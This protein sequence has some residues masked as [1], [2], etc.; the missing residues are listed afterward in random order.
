MPVIKSAIKKLRKDLKRTKTND[1]IRKTLESTVK[2]ARKAKS[3][4]AVQ[5]AFSV[6]DKAKK[7]HI[8]HKNR[9]ARVKSS[10]SKLLVKKTLP[11]V[12]KT[13]TPKKTTVAA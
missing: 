10:L 2:A 1:A 11:P 7:N 13:P 5:K 4:K 6:L 9:A 8:L 12:K 3:E